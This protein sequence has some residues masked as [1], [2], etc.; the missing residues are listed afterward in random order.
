VEAAPRHVL[1][2]CTASQKIVRDGE[3]AGGAPESGL[4]RLALPGPNQH[5]GIPPARVPW[6]VF[7]AR[8]VQARAAAPVLISTL[9]EKFQPA[10]LKRERT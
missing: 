7:D 3:Q 5:I 6:A 10:N 1:N 9:P 4:S 2:E 8:D